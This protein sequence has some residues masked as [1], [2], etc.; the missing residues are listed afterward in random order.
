MNKPIARLT[1]EGDA[2]RNGKRS[3]RATLSALRPVPV[4]EFVGNRCG[5]RA[6]D[7]GGN[8]RMHIAQHAPKPR[9][10]GYYTVTL[11]HDLYG[12]YPTPPES[13]GHRT[14]RVSRIRHLNRGRAVIIAAT[15][16]PDAVE[17]GETC[18]P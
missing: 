3:Y 1:L 12:K 11:G 9:I 17:M 4:F 14:D 10:G 5:D 18:L 6:A 8:C 15:G 7:N 16:N 13:S 2:V